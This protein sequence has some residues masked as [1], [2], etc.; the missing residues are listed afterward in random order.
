MLKSKVTERGQT[1]L[2]KPVRDRLRLRPGD[3]IAFI[4]EGDRF[5]VVKASPALPAEDPFATFTEWSSEADSE[6]YAKL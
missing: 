3:E 4:P 2:P 6:A 1:T 5:V